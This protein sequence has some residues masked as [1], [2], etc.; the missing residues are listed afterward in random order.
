M[1][2]GVFRRQLDSMSVQ[3][4]GVVFTLG[5]S[6]FLKLTEARISYFCT[7]F[8]TF[9]V[10]KAFRCQ[11]IWQ[12]NMSIWLN[13]MFCFLKEKQIQFLARC[14]SSYLKKTSHSVSIGSDFSPNFH[15]IS[16]STVSLVPCTSH[17]TV[18]AAPLQGARACTESP[19]SRYLEKERQSGFYINKSFVFKQHC[20]N[21]FL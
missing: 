8:P 13:Q 9:R 1:G 4:S 17:H 7:I 10:L 12:H 6:L 18:S 20:F 19:K 21:Y 3:H 5:Y 2:T 14:P 11:D 15:F 16:T